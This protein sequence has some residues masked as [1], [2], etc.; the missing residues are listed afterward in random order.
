MKVSIFFAK[1]DHWKWL[2]FGFVAKPLFV[3]WIS[4]HGL[5][6]KTL[7]INHYKRFANRLWPLASYVNAWQNVFPPE[8]PNMG[9]TV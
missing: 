2:R 7:L 4:C 5:F 9:I 3:S 6:S 1:T 8:L